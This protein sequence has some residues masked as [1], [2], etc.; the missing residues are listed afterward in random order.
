MF[1]KGRNGQSDCYMLMSSHSADGVN[2]I[3][4]SEA[5]ARYRMKER[6]FHDA[7]QPCAGQQRK[8]KSVQ[9]FTLVKRIHAATCVSQGTIFGA[10]PDSTLSPLLTSRFGSS[11]N[12]AAVSQTHAEN[13]SLLLPKWH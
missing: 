7:N 5:V 6:P 9:Y 10:A 1:L 4:V 8:A 11:E 13:E 3:L 12:E 2:N